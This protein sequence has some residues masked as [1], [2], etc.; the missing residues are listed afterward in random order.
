MK[1]EEKFWK[2]IRDCMWNDLGKL[3]TKYG[4]DIGEIAMSEDFSND[5]KEFALG[6]QIRGLETTVNELKERYKEDFGK[7]FNGEFF[8]GPF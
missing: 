5:E 2:V 8:D 3:I 4:I 1:N 6:V 7:K